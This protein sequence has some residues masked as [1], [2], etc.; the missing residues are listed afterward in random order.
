MSNQNF[1][2]ILARWRQEAQD[3]EVTESFNITV[4]QSDLHRLRALAQTFNQSIESITTEL[5][6]AAINEI[7]AGMPYEAGEKVIRVEEGQEI[8]EDAGPTPI[9][10][11]ALNQQQQD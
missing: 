8:Y 7:E 2:D 10:L 1:L 6:H 9:Y 11:A 4:N 3:A 5:L